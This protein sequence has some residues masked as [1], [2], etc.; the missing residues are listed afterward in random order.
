[1]PI[2]AARGCKIAMIWLESRACGLQQSR[3]RVSSEQ[4]SEQIGPE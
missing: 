3:Q 1:M 4:Q 2:A